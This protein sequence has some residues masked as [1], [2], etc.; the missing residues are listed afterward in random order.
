MVVPSYASA[1]LIDLSI[2]I[3][4]SP[5]TDVSTGDI[6]E[7][8]ITITNNGPDDAGADSS[9]S[10]PVTVNSERIF[11]EANGGFIDF[12]INTN[13]NQDCVFQTIILD[14]VP[15]DLVSVI[16]TFRTPVIPAGSSFTC[17]GFYYVN[18]DNETR[19]MEWRSN[20]STDNDTNSSNDAF[21]MSFRGQ[22]TPVPSLSIYSLILLG[23]VMTFFAYRFKTTT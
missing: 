19:S 2:E 10:F 12:D 21:L 13:I 8:N 18:F 3:N 7:F 5:I 11:L 14:P 17:H 6:G 1:G 15:G 22:V 20:S 16:Y 4:P 9:L 23:L